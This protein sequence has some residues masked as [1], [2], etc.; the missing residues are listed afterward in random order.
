MTFVVPAALYLALCFAQASHSPEEYLTYFWV[1]I[2]EAPLLPFRR[3]FQNREPG[4]VDR[5]SFVAFNVAFDG[6]DVSFLPVLAAWCS[7]VVCFCFRNG[8][9]WQRQRS[10]AL[11]HCSAEESLLFRLRHCRLHLSGGKPYLSLRY[12]TALGKKFYGQNW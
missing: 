8:F 11:W 2:F 6:V 1:H 3:T 12:G 10:S 5:V 4:K 9:G 7:V